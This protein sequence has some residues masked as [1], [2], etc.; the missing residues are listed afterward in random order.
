MEQG[1]QPKT[2]TVLISI[3]S[4]FIMLFMLNLINSYEQTLIETKNKHFGGRTHDVIDVKNLEL[5]DS[6]DKT[7]CNFIKI[8]LNYIRKGL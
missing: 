6:S 2:I 5:K 7:V 3:S 4:F 1:N 8:I